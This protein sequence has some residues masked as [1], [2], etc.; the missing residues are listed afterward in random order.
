VADVLY[1]FSEDPSI[2][3][4]RPHVPA[5]NP[6]H[7]PGVWAIDDEHAPLY[8]FPRNCPRVTAWPR[9][10]AERTAFVAAWSTAARRV[11]A[12][13]GRWLAQVRA[14]TVYRYRLPVDSFER[15][16]AA[17]GQWFS[18]RDVAPIG[19]DAIADLVGEHAATGIELRVV[20]S[21]WPLHDLAVGGP[22]DFSVVRMRNASPRVVAPTGGRADHAVGQVRTVS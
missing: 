4:F 7:R 2:A 17:S 6:G 14:T 16:P 11:H 8:W 9:D 5:T 1:H 19:V 13:E 21:L 20:P 3:V 10:D 18:T 15:W 12:F 22:W